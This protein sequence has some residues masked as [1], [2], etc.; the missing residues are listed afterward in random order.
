MTT[1]SVAQDKNSE[2]RVLRAAKVVHIVVIV[3]IVVCTAQLIVRF[4]LPTDGW[5]MLTSDLD[6][7]DWI[8]LENLVGAPSE[9]L[10]D[11]ELHAVDGLSVRGTATAIYKTPPPG[12]RVGETVAMTVL[13]DGRQR[14]VDVPVVNWTAAAIW[15]RNVGNPV[16]LINLLGASMLFTVG[17]FTFRRRRELP[18]S[19]ALLMLCTAI[20]LIAL[21]GVLPDGLIG[22]FFG[23]TIFPIVLAPSLLAFT[24][25][26]P[27]P[28]RAIA[29]RPEWA[30]SPYV[31]GLF[32]GVLLYG[33][34]PP[35]IGWL[36]TLS[37][38]VLS[39]LSLAHSAFTQRDSVSRAQLR[40]AIGGTGLGL[41]MAL[42]I[43]PAAFNLLPDP[44]AEIASAGSSVGFAIIGVSLAMAVLRYR[45]FDIEIIVRRTLIYTVLTALLAL[46]YFGSVVL[47]Q[48][49]SER[50][51]GQGSQIAVVISTLLIAAIFAPLRSRV[52]ALIDRRFFRRK[53]DAQRSLAD[54]GARAR[55]EVNLD[56]LI[57]AL[58]QVVNDT[59]EPE[60][61]QIWL[62]R[63]EGEES[64]TI[65]K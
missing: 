62:R 48:T 59:V 10:R 49:L 55:D 61:V 52:Q 56:A 5:T 36:A 28:K 30:L 63:S 26:F 46:I 14:I 11:D 41:V 33:D 38:I 8:Y 40:W 9:L 58:T 15:R 43:F 45:L 4:T 13:T 3:L 65:L 24:L 44:W 2:A 64:G 19:H 1:L 31:I 54:F 29:H 18:A 22:S 16:Q 27:R 47:L 37:M 39:I 35:I 25:L 60:G 53:Y 57:A 32:L 42:F 34:G 20:F 51:T 6:Q 23:F 7:P 50:V 17:Y 21:T 12:W